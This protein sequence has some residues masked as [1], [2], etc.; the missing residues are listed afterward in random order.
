M[1]QGGGL[2]IPPTWLLLDNQSTVDVFANGDMLEDIHQVDDEMV[3]ASNGGSN[4]TSEMGTVP[5]Y[6]LVWY[7][8]VGIANI[9]SLSRVR[10]KYHVSFNSDNNIFIVTKPDGTVFEFK[11]SESGLYYYDLVSNKCKGAVMV[12]TVASKKSRYTN[13]D[14]SRAIL[15][16]QLQIRVGH[17]SIKDFL[18]IVA[19]NQLPNCP[20]TRD[21]ILAAEDIFGPDIGSLKGKMTRS[22]PHRVQSAV[23][24]LPLEIIERYRSLTL[25]ADL[26]YVNGIP[27]LLTISRNLKFGTIEALPNRLEATLIAGLVSTV[28]VYKQCGFSMSLGLTDGEFNTPGIW[29]SLAG[30]GVALNST[31]RDEHVGDIERYVRTMKERMRATYNTLPFTP[32]PPRLVIEMAKQAVFWL[33]LFP[34][35]DGVSDHMS[36]REIMTGQRLDYARHCRFEYGEYVQTHEQ[37]DSSMTPRTI[38]A[39]ALWPTGNAQGTWYFM[40]LSTGRVLKR[41]DAT[42]LP[43]PHEVIDAVHR[44]A[45]Q[46][47]ANS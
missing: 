42:Q 6:G 23:S 46:Q 20:I 5:G 29:E 11:Q 15:A 31:G 36:P 38:G 18:R 1:S 14:D 40:S 47:K 7:D 19:R 2:T 4:V 16:R 3:I 27:F 9:V 12:D 24:P 25:C 22:K 17:P 28:R 39:L 41:N 8:P 44:M 21:D 43:M 26:M 35:V 32:M 33:H 34:K 45:R 37:H 10:E 13:E 30:E